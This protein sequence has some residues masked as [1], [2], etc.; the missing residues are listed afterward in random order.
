MQPE[1]AIEVHGRAR[2]ARLRRPDR[3]G[4]TRT[5]V[6]TIA[7][8][9]HHAEAVD[10]AALEDGHEHLPTRICGQRGA[11]EEPWRRGDGGQRA[12][13]AFEERASGEHGHRHRR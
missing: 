5:G 7:V 9:D 6:V 12:G 3:D 11:R 10:R 8:R 1:E 4:R 13:A 2:V